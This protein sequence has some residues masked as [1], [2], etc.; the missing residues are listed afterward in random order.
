MRKLLCKSAALLMLG[1]TSAYADTG[2]CSGN[3]GLKALEAYWSDTQF[4]AL[5][6]KHGEWTKA[7]EAADDQ[8]IGLTIKN[9]IIK[10]NLGWHE[11]DES[12]HC[13]RQEADKI[14]L[15]TTDGKPVGSGPYQRLGSLKRSEAELYLSRLIKGCF[16]SAERERWCFK[17]GKLTINGKAVKAR[18]ELDLSELDLYGTPLHVQGR[19]L[20]FLYL[21]KRGVN[22][23]VFEDDYTSSV[24]RKAVDPQ[25]SKPWRILTPA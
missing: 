2:I 12:T 24:N 22:W 7:M 8:Q 1:S 4:L 16:V 10:R 20:P 18:L 3:P 11:G 21:V 25:T 9:G 14:W 15:L 23:A 17:Q 19:K 5:L 13:L 6:D